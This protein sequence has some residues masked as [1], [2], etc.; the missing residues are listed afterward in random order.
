VIG[1]IP[2]YAL[3][4]GLSA[5]GRMLFGSGGPKLFGGNGRAGEGGWAGLTVVDLDRVK[6]EP[7]QP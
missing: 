2:I 4:L 7:V 6:L 3:A 1:T 5:D